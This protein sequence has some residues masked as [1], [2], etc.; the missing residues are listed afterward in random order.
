MN[1][2]HITG[3]NSWGGNEQQ[4]I[5]TCIELK[6]FDTR[7]YIYCYHKSPIE[8]E[9]F[10]NNIP[11]VNSVCHKTF[12]LKKARHLKKVITQKNINIIH[13]HTSDSVTTYVISDILFNLNTPAVFSKKGLNS[14]IKRGLSAYKYNYSKIKQVICVSNAVLTSFSA[15]LKP[16]NSHKLK[17]VY[18][19][20]NI[21]RIKINQTNLR[22]L[23]QI[24]S[25][26]LLIGNIAN[27]SKA[28]D[29]KT[30]IKTANHL[31]NKLNIK[32]VVFLQIG[33]NSKHTEELNTLVIEYNL[34][35]HVIFTDFLENASGYINQFDMYLMSSEREGLPI[36]IYES[37]YQ[38]TPVISTIAGGI[39]E[40]ITDGINGKLSNIKDYKSLADNVVELMSSTELKNQF[41]EKSYHLVL[42]KFTTKQLAENTLKI[43]KKIIA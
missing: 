27:H 2:L 16:K 34:E 10:T 6:K 42:D 11:V 4:L 8:K 12:S 38:K 23:Y 40:A 25:S 1:I 36:T 35:N 31:I 26:K 20:I 9:A 15:T 22:D 18:D 32:N 33:K 24:P 19:G 13:L 39:P 28:K 17:V 7:N 41:I 43:Y 29:L 21:D 37:F 30:F 14:K 5:D 3:A